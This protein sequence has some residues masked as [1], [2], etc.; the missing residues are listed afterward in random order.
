MLIYHGRILKHHLDQTEISL[1]ELEAAAR[2]HGV[3]KIENVD[4]AVLEADGNISVLSNNF[5]HK[6]THRRKG[7]KVIERTN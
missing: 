3:D 4:L 5:N 1:D 7:H 6:T 2:E